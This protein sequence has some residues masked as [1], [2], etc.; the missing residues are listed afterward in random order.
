MTPKS[1][2]QQARSRTTQTPGLFPEPAPDWL[3]PGITYLPAY[4]DLP[5]QQALRDEIRAALAHA[6]FFDPT[7]PRTGKPWSIR[8]TNLGTLGW[9]SD[10]NGYRY[11]P[12]HPRT[13]A[14]WPHLPEMLGNLWDALTGG[15]A[16]P[17]CCLV[18]FYRGPR[19]RMG[20]HQ[21]R[22][23]Q[24]LEAPV[25]S[26]SLGDTCLFRIGGFARRDPTRSLR[27]ASGDVLL[28][29]GESRLRF[30]GVDRLLPGSSDLLSGGG[31]LNLTLRRVAPLPLGA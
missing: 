26:V 12:E 4:L 22:D 2:A 21:D 8:M 9:V 29:G 28:I 16:R 23:E 15:L 17:E 31:R 7:M 14:P 5:T 19:A 11:Q 6:P 27:L 18:N 13:G 24:A 30:H 10:R 1:P 25:L 3:P 20:L